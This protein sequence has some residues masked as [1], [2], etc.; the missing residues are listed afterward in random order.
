MATEKKIENKIKEHLDSIGAYWIKNHGSRYSRAG[1][2]DLTVCYLGRFVAVEVKA[3]DEQPTE[4]QKYNIKKIRE[5]GGIAI[6]ADN[7][8]IVIETFDNL[9]KEVLNGKR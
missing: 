7:L 1:V 5:S 4:L 9:R 8:K 3:P 6:L 2:L